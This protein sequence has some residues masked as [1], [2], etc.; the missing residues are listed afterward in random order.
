MKTTMNLQN[1]DSVSILWATCGS[2]KMFPTIDPYYDADNW[3]EAVRG[4]GRSYG[5]V[6]EW[7]TRNPGESDQAFQKRIE[8][9]EKVVEKELGNR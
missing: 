6:I 5:G 7:V 2:P 3:H 9:R 1:I 8:E 4:D